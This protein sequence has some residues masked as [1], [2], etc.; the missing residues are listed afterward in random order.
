MFVVS[1]GRRVVVVI[2]TLSQPNILV[3]MSWVTPTRLVSQVT[4]AM[5]VVSLNSSQEI[6]VSTGQII[7][8]EAMLISSRFDL[9]TEE[10]E[11]AEKSVNT[12]NNITFFIAMI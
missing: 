7:S 2:T 5:F 12:N 3:N 9:A 4:A 6:V 10:M 11:N 8:R 1:P